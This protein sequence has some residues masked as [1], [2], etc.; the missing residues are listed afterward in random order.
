MSSLLPQVCGGE[1]W[2][3]IAGM[4]IQCSRERQG[5]VSLVINCRLKV[6][7]TQNL[8]CV[9]P[10]TVPT[11][12]YCFIGWILMWPSS[13]PVMVAVMLEDPK[14]T[15]QHGLVVRC[16]MYWSSPPLVD[17]FAPFFT[18]GFEEERKKKE[19]LGNNIGAAH[20]HKAQYRSHW[21][22]IK[23]PIQHDSPQYVVRNVAY[24]SYTS[25]QLLFF[26]AID[27]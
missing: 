2:L 20:L 23:F 22:E 15:Q 9:V 26:G 7:R 27:K 5:N 25:M 10:T 8:F 18:D 19:L 6:L 4:F 11:R 13:L 16:P 12:V 14:N 24:G 21:V 3:A 17:A 1:R